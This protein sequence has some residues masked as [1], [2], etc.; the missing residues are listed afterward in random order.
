[1]AVRKLLCNDQWQ[2]IEHLLPGKASDP[3]RTAADNRSFVEAVLWIAPHG[4]AL[5]RPAGAVWT[6]E[7]RVP[8]LLALGATRRVAADVRGAGQGRLL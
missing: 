2:R 5:T 7:Q 1:M 4:R 3:G 6:L 8:A